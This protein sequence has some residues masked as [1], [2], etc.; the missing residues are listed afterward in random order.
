MVLPLREKVTAILLR[1][2]GENLPK[3]SRP[4]PLNREEQTPKDLGKPKML[5]LQNSDLCLPQIFGEFRR[6]QNRARRP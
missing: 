2:W 3:D 1:Y 5:L 4:E 6:S